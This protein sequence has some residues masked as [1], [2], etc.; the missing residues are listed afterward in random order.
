MHGSLFP[1][2]RP[3]F[4]AVRGKTAV[5]GLGW[6]ADRLDR[7][8]V[9]PSSCEVVALLLFDDPRVSRARHG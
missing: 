5:G 8:V 9:R 6:T 1:A 2:Q 7:R 4:G 3:I